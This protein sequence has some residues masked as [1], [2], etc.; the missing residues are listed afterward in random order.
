AAQPVH[1]PATQRRREARSV[2]N[3]PIEVRGAALLALQLDHL[4]VTGEVIILAAVDE[5]DDQ[6]VST[7]A[8]RRQGRCH[9][10]R[11]IA[12]VNRLLYLDVLEPD[13]LPERRDLLTP[14]RQT[15]SQGVVVGAD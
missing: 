12:L 8:G 11:F 1:E 3:R 14:Q 13:A 5:F 10:Q 7:E 9:R 6:F 2:A 4:Q 15:A